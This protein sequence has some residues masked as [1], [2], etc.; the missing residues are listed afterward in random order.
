[1]SRQPAGC[2]PPLGT[3]DVQKA[4]MKAVEVSFFNAVSEADKSD[5]GL[6]PEGSR[7]GYACKLRS[8]LSTL[9]AE[10]ATSGYG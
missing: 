5:S 2:T 4:C 10:F 6:Q 3:A 1:M 8:V 9:F 7:R